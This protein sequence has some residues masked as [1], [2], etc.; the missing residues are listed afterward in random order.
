[1]RIAVIADIHSNIVSLNE[2]LF[3][4]GYRNVDSIVCLGDLVGYAPYP[5]EVIDNIRE[6]KIL[7]IKGNYDEAVGEE[8]M[9]CG[10]D[11]PDPK[12]AEI[13]GISLN[14]TIEETREDNKKFL[15]N[16]PMEMNMS[17]EGKTIKFVHGS[18]RKINEYLK[19]NSKEAEEVMSGFDGDILVCGHTHKPYYKIYG[20]KMLVN[21]G[22]AGRP[23]TGT[24]KANY[25]VIDL[26]GGTP[27]VEIYEVV[28][29][30]ERVAKATEKMGLPQEFADIIRTGKA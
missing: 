16:L 24:P 10:C 26:Y 21:A 27:R 13:A 29:A 23:K 19:E 18:P 2:V 22:S 5:N 15:K 25:V 30:Y 20:S 3:D 14:W 12:D 6:N 7:T 4:I 9:V 17:F 8:L 1:M 28:Y 11:Y